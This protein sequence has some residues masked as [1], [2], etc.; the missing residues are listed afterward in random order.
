MMLPLAAVPFVMTLVMALWVFTCLALI[1]IIMIQKGKGGGLAAA[2]GGGTSSLF[3]AKTGDFL[4]WVTIGI[5]G[6]FLLLSV[7]M[8][9]YYEP[10]VTVRDIAPFVAPT[11]PQ[12]DAPPMAPQDAPQMPAAP[13][14]TEVPPMAPQDV[15]QAPAVPPQAEEAAPN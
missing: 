14:Q 13:P 8:G 5:A 12:A 9:L 7:F 10:M 11:P 1:F 4:T 6:V 2:F 15:P 3:G